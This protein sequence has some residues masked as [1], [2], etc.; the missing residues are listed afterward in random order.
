MAMPL[1]RRLKT[2]QTEKADAVTEMQAILDEADNK[3]LSDE[4]E[5]TYAA[6]E[7]TL[8][9]INPQIVRVER[10]LAEERG[11]DTTIDD[12]N[13]DTDEEGLDRD[14][15][16]TIRDR[17]RDDPSCGYR[18]PDHFMLEV[19]EFGQNE[20]EANLTP[21][22]KYL[23]AAG[24]D[25]AGGY[26]DPVGGF[27]VP[28]GLAPV[29]L[30]VSPEVD[31][32]A[33]RV[34]QVPMTTPIVKTNARVDKNHTT[35][36]S[37]GLTVSRTPETG[38]PGSS[39]TK[40]E[41]IRLEAT[42][43]FGLSYVTEQ[44]LERS[45]ISFAA[46]LSAGFQD[47]FASSG[48]KERYRGTGNG[49]PL[50]ILNSPALL[51]VAK[52]SMQVADTINGTN[53]IK[54]RQRVW[55]YGQ[56]IWLANHDTLEQLMTC[57]IAGT[58]SDV[59]LFSPGRGVD[60]PDTLLGRPIIFTEYANTLGDLGDICC[61]VWS[62]Y[63]WGTMGPQNPRRAESIHVRFLNHE[64]TFKFWIENDGA[65]WWRALLTPHKSAETLSPFVALAERA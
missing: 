37:G 19:I 23:A 11:M 42:G 51:S 3:A 13:T 8:E 50:G 53:V 36:V 28:E 21:Q 10:L 62:Q 16:G 25:E 6:L 45:P 15:I 20:S 49:E 63:L 58:N 41:Q 9:S 14:G 43:L 33:S 30:S 18:D 64:R 55:R 59:F 40:Y 22:L 4:Q 54:M 1:S 48:L 57:H 34:T 29:T 65:P 47:E 24:S 35:S 27:F 2:L 32:T 46:I 26:S 12:L 7:A 17:W 61:G 56:A 31:P 38:A 60:V 39:R 44:L 5:K 52:Q